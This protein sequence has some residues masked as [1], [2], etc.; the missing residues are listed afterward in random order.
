VIG[1]PVALESGGK[2]VYLILHAGHHSGL[3][4]NTPDA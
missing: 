4:F 3:S 2:A 1:M